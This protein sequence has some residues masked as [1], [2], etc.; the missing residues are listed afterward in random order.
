M[1]DRLG[2]Q[3]QQH[4]VDA[5]HQVR[6]VATW[7]VVPANS[8][9]V[10]RVACKYDAGRGLVIADVP[11]GMP[12]RMEHF[13][14]QLADAQ[15]LTVA[16]PDI[17]LWRGLDLNAAQLSAAVGMEQR[18][19][20]AVNGQFG[21]RRLHNL[22]IGGHHVPMGV[23]NEH[24]FDAH[25]QPHSRDFSQDSRCILAWINHSPFKGV[26]TGDDVAVCL[27]WSKR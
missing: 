20:V 16:Q 25:V 27:K 2:R 19:I 21:A 14:C 6:I 12:R 13:E 8:P 11:G 7:Q 26:W 17:G 23:G 15:H 5:A 10:K 9:S 18:H 4:L 22:G 24:V 1:D 3:S